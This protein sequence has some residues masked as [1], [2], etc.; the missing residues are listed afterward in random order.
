VDLADER[1]DCVEG[2]IAGELAE[3]EHVAN[4]RCS[5]EC[6]G[7]RECLER[8]EAGDVLS[9]ETFDG[10]ADRGEGL[11]EHQCIG[12]GLCELG[13]AGIA[14]RACGVLDV[15]PAGAAEVLEEL[16]EV[17]VGW[18][19]SGSCRMVGQRALDA[20]GFGE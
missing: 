4:Q 8:A 6:G 1:G 20:G 18:E 19:P 16:G 14:D 11:G 13:V 9:E 3:Q 7:G 12:A 15:E 17:E 2:L 5:V 10:A